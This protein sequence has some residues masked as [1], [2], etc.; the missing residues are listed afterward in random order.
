[1]PPCMVLAGHETE[2]YAIEWNP[3]KECIMVGGSF[4]GK[5]TMWD[6]NSNKE[7]KKVYP[8]CHFNYHEKEIEDVSHHRFHDSLFASCDDG[9]KTALW[10]IRH[11]SFPLCHFSTTANEQRCI[12][13]SPLNRHLFATAGSDCPIN[14]WDVRNMS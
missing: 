10:D 1:M 8:I 6:L 14:F 4:D 5:L 11:P 3:H 9:G 13:F 12:Q 7:N 2:G